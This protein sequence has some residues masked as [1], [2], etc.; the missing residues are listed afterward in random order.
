MARP[1]SWMPNDC[2]ASIWIQIWCPTIHGGQEEEP[3]FPNGR[4]RCCVNTLPSHPAISNVFFSFPSYVFFFVRGESLVIHI[5]SFIVSF[6]LLS[7]RI[8][9]EKRVNGE[10]IYR[11]DRNHI[12][13][14]MEDMVGLASSPIPGNHGVVFLFTAAWVGFI[15]TERRVECDR[16]MKRI[17]GRERESFRSFFPPIKWSPSAV[18]LDIIWDWLWGP[19]KKIILAC[20]SRPSSPTLCIAVNGSH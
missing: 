2:L 16:G 13:V 3:R 18:D 20:L 5:L 9:R 7:R 17:K 19:E 11:P 8:R 15:R 4:L 6:P 14:R 12:C 10:W 1:P